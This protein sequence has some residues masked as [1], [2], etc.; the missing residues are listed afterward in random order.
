MSSMGPWC[1]GDNLDRKPLI[2]IVA[3][4]PRRQATLRPLMAAIGPVRGEKEGRGYTLGDGTQLAR[5]L[6]ADGTRVKRQTRDGSELRPGRPIFRSID[7]RPTS[8]SGQP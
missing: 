2:L 7:L 3:Q 1:S 6:W 5:P 4:H 8:R